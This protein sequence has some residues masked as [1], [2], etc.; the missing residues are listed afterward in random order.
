MAASKEG[1]LL[2]PR[3]WHDVQRAYS[4]SLPYNYAV[5]DDF[6]RADVCSLVHSGLV[7]HWGWR[8]KNWSSEHLHNNQPNIPEAPVI[9]EE[10]LSNLPELLGGR[11]LITYWAL[12]YKKNTPGRVHADTAGITLTVWLTPDSH[13]LDPTSG[14]LVLYD[15]KRP[16]E[17][18]AH[19]H[20][21]SEWS[22]PYVEQHTKGDRIRVPY[23]CN[24]AVL[25]DGKTFH[26]T[27]TLRFAHDSPHSH[28]INLTF[29]FDV[30][31]TYMERMQP[32]LGG[33]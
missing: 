14:G 17:L 21:V 22:E 12:M 11:E 30:P 6:L 5:I 3:D 1:P 31:E 25:F 7:A 32:Y 19:E 23:R 2:T 4:G 16:D 29:A 33:I 15:V 28:R 20:L 26:H 27:D 10:V 18:L 8:Y 9:A 13:N 24:R